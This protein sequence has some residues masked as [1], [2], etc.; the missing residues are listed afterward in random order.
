M[1]IEKMR[2]KTNN[3]FNIFIKKVVAMSVIVTNLSFAI[4]IASFAEDSK[5][6]TDQKYPALVPVAA[7]SII[8][9]FVSTKFSG[10]NAS[11]SS[12]GEIIT[13]YEEKGDGW[14]S[15]TT[16]EYPNG[17]KRTYRNYKQY[18]GSY[19]GIPYWNGNIAS[20]GC[21]PTSVAIVLSGYGYDYDPGKVV[22]TMI[23]KDSSSF[24]HLRQ[25]LKDIGNIDAEDHYGE[26][27]SGDIQTIR[28]NL[29]NGRPVIVNAPGHYIVLIGEDNNGKLIVSDSASKFY[30]SKGDEN[31]VPSVP[32]SPDNLEDF[33]NNGMITC[34]Y[35]LIT[36][37]GNAS[38]NNNNNNTSSKKSTSENT[39][40]KNTDNKTTKTG[41]Y[42]ITPCDVSNG[43]YESIFTSGTT[44]RQFK[45][46]KQNSPKY[47]YPTLNNANWG[48]ECTTVSLAIVGSGYNKNLDMQGIADK[49]NDN[50][51][52]TYFEEFISSWTGQNI[53][54]YNISSKEDL[55]DKLSK[56]Y[57]GTVYDFDYSDD[58]HM[59]AMLDIS[60]DKTE[61]YISNP[62]V[63]KRKRWNWSRMDFN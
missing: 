23:I 15:T 60:K 49:L 6:D 24:E 16:V 57:V 20:D 9:K 36:S 46:F 43:G 8:S 47:N 61:V 55:I 58:G 44:G 13:N 38:S 62:D 17:V 31:N 48:Q 22:E 51:G 59:V 18:E 56:G 40:N 34:G 5:S 26:G 53:Q 21:G 42:K 19:A 39:N 29:K 54:Q 2:Y 45:E 41:E 52:N 35:I 33:V 50:G 10:S 11:S 30:V 28:E 1:L 63:Y 3:K 14:N 7:D 37:D 32:G 27:T 4:P 25:A 12:S